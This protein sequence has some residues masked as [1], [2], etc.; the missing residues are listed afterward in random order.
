MRMHFFASVEQRDDPS[1]R[2]KPVIVGSDPKTRGVVSTCS[3]EAE[4]FRCPF[5]HALLSSLQIV[6]TGD[7]HKT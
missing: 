2:G 4:I 7:F 6:P 5:C 3:Y 1:L